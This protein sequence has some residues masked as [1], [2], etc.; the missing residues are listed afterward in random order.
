MLGP[1]F[2]LDTTKSLLSMQEHSVLPANG[3]DTNSVVCLFLHRN[4]LLV[5]SVAWRY[6]TAEFVS[7]A[8]GRNDT[9]LWRIVG[10]SHKPPSAIDNVPLQPTVSSI[11]N[12]NSGCN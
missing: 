3:S 2:V 11:K 10:D 7:T 4:D 5:F 12:A 9:F 6:S 8:M 1:S